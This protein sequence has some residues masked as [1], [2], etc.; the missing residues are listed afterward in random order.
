MAFDGIVINNLVY[1]FK[2]KILGGNISKIAQPEKDELLLTIKSNKNMYRL[3][4]S[5]N[6][7][8]PL[9]YLTDANKPSPMTAPTF[10]MVL[11][12]HLSNA[13]IVDISQPDYERIIDFKLEHLNELADLCTKHLIVEL[14]GK[15]SNIIF[16]DDN[17]TIIDSIKHISAMVSSVREVLPG[18]DYYIV[19][20]NTK[21]N[22][23]TLTKE[24]FINNVFAKDIPVYKAIYNNLTGISPLIA[25]EICA[26][27]GVF[28]DT[29]TFEL[30][31]DE[32]YH[33]YN[34]FNH[35]FED[36]KSNLFFPNVVL[37]NNT[38]IEYSSLPLN[39]YKDLQNK[40]YESIST[41]IEE[42]YI[43]KSIYTRMQQKSVSLRK[44][45]SNHLER[46]TKKYDL[47]LKQL[48]DTEKMDKYKLYGELITAYA[49]DISPKSKEYMALNYYDNSTIKI[50]LDENLSAT[51]N[52]N[53]YYA[54]YNKLKRTHLALSEQIIETKDEITH[55]ESISASLEMAISEDDLTSIKKELTM[56]GYIKAALADKKG[57]KQSSGKNDNKPYHYISR[58]GYDIYVGRNNLQ[59]DELTFKLAQNEDWWFHVKGSAGSHVVVKSKG[60]EIP[61]TVYE[62]AGALAAF[63][64]K[65][66]M[67]SKVEIDYTIKKNVKKPNN[68]KPGFVVYYTNYSLI[69]TP[70][71]SNL[72]LVDYWL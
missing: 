5:A 68:G 32:R 15:H 27:A 31:E 11:R 28:S 59:N 55:L 49:Y 14:M 9:C 29:N 7:S 26:R 21:L 17:G 30:N 52:A 18:R 50:T 54:K 23:L 20:N 3:L 58:D 42:Y 41:L 37:D 51:E 64:S 38:P 46:A 40:Y 62:D 65:E 43:S 25:N 1:E 8:L 44:I 22:P 72:K 13:R 60:T 56:Y 34:V 16:T 39:V 63:Y 47:Q 61:D 33:V 57:K 35:M 53:K 6:A 12:K 2:N 66:R 48:K 70:D 4:I 71:I 69:A 36:I 19:N 67:A 24:D 45:V 10:C